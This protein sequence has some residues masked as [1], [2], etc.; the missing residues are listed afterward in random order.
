MD[1]HF[2]SVKI[3]SLKNL[4]VKKTD[5]FYQINLKVNLLKRKNNPVNIFKQSKIFCLVNILFL[6][7]LMYLSFR[8]TSRSFMASNIR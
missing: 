4:A 1:F 6:S 5:G 3:N 2:I 7:S 8:G